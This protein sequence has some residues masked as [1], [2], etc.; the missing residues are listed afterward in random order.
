[1]LESDLRANVRGLLLRTLVKSLFEPCSWQ[2]C[3]SWFGLKACGCR[4]MR[5][6]QLAKKDIFVCKLK[7]K[8][9]ISLT[10]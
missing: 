10:R 6:L 9:L 2:L 4:W 3:E 7:I 5:K 1:M 8:L